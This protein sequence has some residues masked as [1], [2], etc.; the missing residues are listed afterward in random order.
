VLTTG[1]FGTTAGTFAQGN[2][3]RLS[4]A[5][6]PL[7]HT[8]GD[9][10]NAGAIATTAVAPE[11]N[12]YI[13]I[14]DSSASNVLKRGILINSAIPDGTFLANNGTFSHAQTTIGLANYD[15]FQQTIT[16]TTTPTLSANSISLGAD[17]GTFL[18]R[19]YFLT[20]SSVSGSG[21]R[22][23]VASSSTS[24]ISL[25]GG[26]LALF[27]TSVT[28]GST[29]EDSQS[30]YTLPTSTSVFTAGASVLGISGSLSTPAYAIC[31]MIVAKSTTNSISIRFLF[32]NE[33]SATLTIRNFSM[34][35][36]KISNLLF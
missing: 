23:G 30:I 2:D 12:D 1:S 7:S 6:T 24:G 15:D 33:V 10:S 28:Q 34:F 22:F 14:S 35:A 20:T 18:I 16:S 4:D 17:T 19:A 13:I 36:T 29:G 27:D 25:K 3:S 8:H 26:K 11:S 9:I 32:G 5:R 21:V 31:E